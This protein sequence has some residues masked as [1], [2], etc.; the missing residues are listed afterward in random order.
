MFETKEDEKAPT[1]VG[2]RDRC[3]REVEVTLLEM[4]CQVWVHIAGVSKEGGCK[5]VNLTQRQLR[6]IAMVGMEIRRAGA[7]GTSPA[8][9]N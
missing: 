6:P 9:T 2:T 7:P 8:H 5:A 3:T 1:Q 4:A